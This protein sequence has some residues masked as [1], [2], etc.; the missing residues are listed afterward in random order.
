MNE[1][2]KIK[3]RYERRKKLPKDFYSI[4]KIGNL[5]IFQEREKNI[6]KLL[7]KYEINKLENKKILD[8]GC[9]RGGLLRD[10]IKYGAK[11]ENLYGI[12]LLA[13][14]IKEAKEIN[15]NINFTCANA[16]KLDF[17]D[18]SFDIVLQ[19]VC[20]TSIFDTNIKKKIAKEMLRVIKDNGIILWY[21]FKY[22][23]PRNSDV[24]GIK[25]TEIKKL[26]PDCYYDFN[27]ITLAPPITRKLAPI[28]WFLC[29]I[30]LKLKF[31]NTHY[32]IIIKKK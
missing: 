8:V 9:G 20:F 5:F 16:E 26:F 4:F 13:E 17:S 18:K 12:D 15:P 3:K 2:D 6:L 29:Y 21:D 27:L 24:K 23:N 10:F 31:L 30:L 22:N 19:S 28:S 14:R 7:K 32:L 25:K 1:I 11:P